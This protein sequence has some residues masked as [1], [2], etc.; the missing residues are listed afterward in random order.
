MNNATLHE[1]QLIEILAAPWYTFEKKKEIVKVSGMTKTEVISIDEKDIPALVRLLDHDVNKIRF[2]A[3]ILL[4]LFEEKA[5]KYLPKIP[6]LFG[7]FTEKEQKEILRSVKMINT[8]KA[9]ATLEQLLLQSTSYDI[10]FETVFNISELLDKY[11]LQGIDLLLQCQAKKDIWQIVKSYLQ[12]ALNKASKP[13]DHQKELVE[14]LHK[15]ILIGISQ[16]AEKRNLGMEIIKEN[17]LAAILTIEKIQQSQEGKKSKQAKN[18]LQKVR[19]K[20]KE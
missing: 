8:E 3:I 11:P 20:T 17:I 14:K 16:E 7:Q 1:K 12:T 4:G 18:I 15:P 9:L 13:L 5:S 10:L 19:K 2:R 6:P